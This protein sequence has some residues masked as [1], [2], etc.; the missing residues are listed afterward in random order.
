MPLSWNEIRDRAM[1][2]SHEWADVSSEDAEAKP[3]WHSFFEVFGVSRRRVAT[4]EERVKKIDGKDG[5]IDLLWKGILLIEHKSRGKDLDR[6]HKQAKDYFHGLKERDL[7]RYI[8]VSDFERFRLYD[9]EDNTQQEFNLKELHKNIKLFGFIAGYQT[10]KFQE[11]D[12]VNIKAA[13]RMGKLH[14]KLKDIGYDGH[15]LENYLVRIL[16][17]LFAE[18]AGVFERR[19]FQ[20]FIE[21][22]TSEDGSDLAS[23]IAELF[24]VL[25]TPEN[26]RLKNLDEQLTSF[27]YVNGDLFSERLPMASFNKDMRDSLLECCA[28]DWSRISPAIF[29]AMFQ[30]IM[31]ENRR[32]NIGAHYTSEKNI[33]KV[34]GPLFLD[35]LRQEF[36]SCKTSLKKME[37]FHVKLS[38]LKFLDP[39]CGCGNF[40]IISYR[41]IRELELE[42][43]RVILPK[44]I[45][46]FE[47]MGLLDISPQII[48]NVDQFYGIEIEEFPSQIARTALW[49]MDHQMNMRV[50]AEFGQYFSRLPL[51]KSATIV[52]DNALKID[53]KTIINPLE[54]SYI[55][56]NPPFV[57]KQY[58]DDDQKKDMAVIFA[59]VKGA[60]VLDFVT[61]WYIKATDMMTSNTLIK[62]AFVS[63]NSISQGEQV[64]VLWNELSKR[65]I[66]INF[67][68]RTFQWTN[69]ARGVAAVHCVIVGFSVND[70]EHK[71]LFDYE[72]IKS[73]PHEIKASNIN[74]Y[75]VDAPT[76][77][78][79]KRR[80]PVSSAPDLAFG[81]MPN[82]GGYLIIEEDAYVDFLKKEP[83]AKPYIRK[84]IGSEEFINNKNR[85]CLWLQGIPVNELKAMPHVVERV[86]KVKKQREQSK[87]PETK[88]LAN[89]PTLFG[90]IRQPKKDYLAIPEVSS[91]RRPYIP[92]G[93][94]NKDVICSNKIYSVDGANI[95]HFGILAS[96]MHMAWVRYVAGRL[97]SDYQYSNGIVY[98]NFP[99]P[100]DITDKQKRGIEEAAQAILDVRVSHKGSSL[101]DLYDPN[102]MPPD[103]AKAHRALDIAVDAAYSKRKF[104]GDSDRIA[105]LFDLYQKLV[106]PLTAESKKITKR[107]KSSS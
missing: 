11:Q 107:K 105:F 79:E 28:L 19:Q 31:D 64:S 68:H 86:E 56:G 7:P 9:L 32:R 76:V 72:T 13:E 18:D 50:G 12:P 30:S 65:R 46:N 21:Q 82:D 16:F 103:L 70:T 91:E 39:A 102:I 73:D 104:S 53:W 42:A 61:A 26:K 27:R 94:V 92:I 5:Y 47:G 78:L 57:G 35:G 90:E 71:R 45:K 22:R 69:E 66:K 24:E 36:D 60:G 85:Y 67:A 23:R 51:T 44:R 10:T 96:A 43:L 4:F 106:T 89:T 29:G 98:N 14:D 55:F 97:K 49:L 38:K 2:F 25:N 75:L 1:R 15:A 99:W 37:D 20:D 83:K 41:E 34:I 80:T 81:S 63:T 101:S 87:R 88:K 74:P 62:S 54:L 33:M 58:Q 52:H 6:A 100:D 59:D 3:F 17:C 40:L 48:C 84:F 8:L 95:F 93:F 77:F